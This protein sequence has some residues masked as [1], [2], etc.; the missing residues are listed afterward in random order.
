MRLLTTGKHYVWRVLLASEAERFI[1]QNPGW[2]ILD[3][4]EHSRQYIQMGVKKSSKTIVI[5]PL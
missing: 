1:A 4:T 2:S 3:K 5:K